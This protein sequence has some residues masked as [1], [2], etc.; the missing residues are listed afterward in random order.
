MSPLSIALTVFALALVF[1]MVGLILM[2]L[3]ALRER[4]ESGEERGRVEGGAV[5]VV[6]PIPIVFGTSE[7]VTKSLMVLAVVLLIVSV[8]AFVVLSRGA[9]Q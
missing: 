8:I 5:V 3:S 9:V 7:R 1:T 6:G 4:A 2:V